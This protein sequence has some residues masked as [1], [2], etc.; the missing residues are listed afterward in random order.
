MDPTNDLEPAETVDRESADRHEVVDD[1]LDIVEEPAEPVPDRAVEEEE[2]FFDLSDNETVPEDLI[3]EDTIVVDTGQEEEEVRSSTRSRKVWQQIPEYQR[4]TRSKAKEGRSGGSAGSVHFAQQIE[5]Y[6]HVFAAAKTVTDEP[7]TLREALDSPDAAKWRA[8]L[9]CEYHAIQRKK[10]WTLIKRSK[11]KGG[12]RVLR[13]KLVFKKKR[14]KDGNILKYKVRWV[15]R[16]F[17]Q[18]YGKDYDQTY[19]GVCKSVTWKIIL[20]I[21]AVRDW[22][23]EQMDAVTAFLNSQ[24]DGDVYV[25]LPP[26]W[27]E[28]F[29]IKDDD[30]DYV[31]KLLMALYGLKQSPRLWQEKLRKVLEKLGFQPLKVDNCVYINKSGVILVT[32]VD[33]MLITGPDINEIDRVKK[34]LKEEFEMD[35]LGPVNYFL[36]VRIIRNRQNRSIALIQDAYISKILKK[37]GVQNCKPVVTPMEVGTL[38]TMVTNPGEATKAEILDYQS[39]IGSLIYLATHTRPDIAFACSVLSRF[40]VNPSKDHI[41]CAGR[42][43]RYIAGTKNL[44]VVYGG[45]AIKD[46][47][48]KGVLHGYSDSDFAGDVELR[49]STSGYVFFFAGG[50]ISCQS[51]RQTLTALSTT[52]AEYYGLHKAVMEATWLRYIFKELGWTSKDVK[53]VK[54]YGD[55][56]A[57]LQLTENPELH[58]RTK[59][60][61]VKYHYI[62]EARAKGRVVF[63]YCGT[64]DMAADGLTKPLARVKHQRFVAQLGLRVIEPPKVEGK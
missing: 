19:A 15:V 54:I 25:E 58:Q 32:Y 3:P 46:D 5:T 30:P 39:K 55:N 33:D 47:P 51:K 36:G 28:I 7:Q 60:I 17:E 42:V 56:Q 40:L 64:N 57:S 37:Y 59:H 11:V 20:A 53:R 26:L 61:A 41:D 9:K 16:G 50:V 6:R 18:Q 21:A 31:C 52:E 45:P 23:I 10:T 12:Q 48:D 62:R 35:D 44:A 4:M 43:L 24:I 38:N 14:D 13:G 1:S 34:A 2:E 8:A 22:E 27:K 29:D 63:W 49:K